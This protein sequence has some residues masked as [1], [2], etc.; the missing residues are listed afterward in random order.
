MNERNIFL[1]QGRTKALHFVMLIALLAVGAIGYLLIPPSGTVSAESGDS[2]VPALVNFEPFSAVTG[3]IKIC[4]RAAA[5]D[6]PGSTTPDPDVQ[7]SFRYTINGVFVAGSNTTLQVFTTA[8]GQC[9]NS[10]AVTLPSG[11]YDV[12]VNELGEVGAFLV[13]ATTVPVDRKIGEVTLNSNGGGSQIV[14]VVE[15]SLSNETIVNFFNR[16]R[17]GQ[18]KVCKIAGPGIPL[19]RIFT[20]RVRG[21]GPINAAGTIGAV[22]TTVNVMAGAPNAQGG[23]G[24]CSFVPGFGAIVGNTERQTFVVGSVILTDELPPVNIGGN[25]VLVSNITTTSTFAPGSPSLV[26]RF[27]D[28]IA[29]R[30]IVEVTYTNFVFQPSILKICKIA[31]SNSL[32]GT[33]FTFD[34]TLANPASGGI[35]PP[36]TIP[37]TVNAGPNNPQG[38]NCQVVGTTGAGGSLLGGAFNQGSTVTITERA[39]GGIFVTNITSTTSNLP[40]FVPGTRTTTLSGENGIVAGVTQVTFTNNGCGF[41]FSNSEPDCTPVPRTPFDFDGDSRADVSVFRP[42]NGVWYINQSSAGFTSI[43]FGQAGDKIVPADYDGDGKTD[44]AVYRLG[45]WY[46]N[47]SQSGFIG[48]NFGTAED[49]PQ[50]A[51]YDGDGKAELAVFRP[52]NGGWYVLNLA[53][54]Q[55]NSVGFGRNGDKPVAADYDGDGK[56][57]IGVF[58]VSNGGWYIQGSQAGIIAIGFGAINDRPVPADYDGDGDTNIALYRPSNGAWLGTTTGS[59][60]GIRFGISTDMPVPADYDGDGKADIAVFR[61]S[62][63]AWYISGSSTGFTG[64]QFGQEGDL[65][66]PNAFVAQ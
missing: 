13:T 26:G 35:F 52:S 9:T 64:I 42:S 49:I 24:N 29:R 44:V 7:G 63:G 40:P 54:N 41:G 59:S 14:R 43:Q 57:D 61:Q 1:F 2:D 30:D 62:E 16:S 60:I 31:G 20:F 4:K 53:N 66:V 25:P 50:P 56:A 32:L 48:V 65:P 58:R 22:D 19:N 23:G 45:A 10:I 15:G 47:R 11:E 33:P 46:L 36:F 51:D 5:I 34:V 55:L 3:H 27:A 6:V 39:A 28:V 18:L 8:V 12:Q 21:R 17:P 37:V 38:G